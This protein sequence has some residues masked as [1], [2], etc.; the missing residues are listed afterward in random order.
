MNESELKEIEE[1]LE[2][3]IAWKEEGVCEP[4]ITDIRKL[5]EEV[6]R[7][8]ELRRTTY[9]VKTKEERL[10][11]LSCDYA[12][13]VNGSKCGW[14]P[15]NEDVDNAVDNDKTKHC[16]NFP[17]CGTAPTS[18]ETCPVCGS[19]KTDSQDLMEWKCGRIVDSY[20]VSL[21]C[22]KAEEIAVER[23][24]EIKIL[25]GTMEVL[26]KENLRYNQEIERLKGGIYAG[27]ASLVEGIN[28]NPK[29]A[30]RLLRTVMKGGSV[31]NPLDI[32]KYGEKDN[33]EDMS[34][35][36]QSVK[37]NFE[38]EGYDE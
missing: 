32:E 16:I 18:G 2:E 20:G 12:G 38:L 6:K 25:Q 4:L 31:T 23:G 10:H 30:L 9:E 8:R 13:C 34:D 24:E 27:V 28:K 1:H 3:Q 19:E 33:P 15:L 5:L 22:G 37:R 29:T 11:D 35:I 26:A 7:L 36:E 21:G 17:Y 14:T